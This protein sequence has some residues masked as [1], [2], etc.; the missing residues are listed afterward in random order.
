MYDHERDL[1]K[2]KTEVKNLENLNNVT[3]R[4]AQIN[5]KTESSRLLVEISK[6]G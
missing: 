2:K 6:N 1:N 4:W 3:Q 5:K